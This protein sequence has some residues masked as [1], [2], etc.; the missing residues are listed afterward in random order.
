M[1]CLKNDIWGTVVLNKGVGP[2]ISGSLSN[3]KYVMCNPPCQLD[4][5]PTIEQ[6][7]LCYNYRNSSGI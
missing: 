4:L 2:K 5:C 6:I 1:P 3:Y 7:Q